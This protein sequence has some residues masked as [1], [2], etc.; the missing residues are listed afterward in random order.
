MLN[1][2]N[3]TKKIGLMTLLISLVAIP[4]MAGTDYRGMTN[5]ELSALRGTMWNA[6]PEDHAAFRVEWQ[7]RLNNMSVKDRQ[8]YAGPPEAAGQRMMSA[9][10]TPGC[11]ANCCCRGRGPRGRQ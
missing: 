5:A 8:E 11:N 2:S 10:D 4:A 7:S 3:L 1:R 6:S 9:Q